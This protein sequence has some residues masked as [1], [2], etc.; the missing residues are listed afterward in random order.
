[1]SDLNDQLNQINDRLNH[2]DTRRV[3]KVEYRHPLIDSMDALRSPIWSYRATTMWESC[4]LYLANIV[5]RD[6]WS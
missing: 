5:R 4:Y 2:N 3:A 6:Q 1:L